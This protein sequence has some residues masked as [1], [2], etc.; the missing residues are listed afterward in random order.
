MYKFVKTLW[1]YKDIPLAIGISKK[2]FL[3]KAGLIVWRFNINFDSYERAMAKERIF[4]IR[5]SNEQLKLYKQLYD[6][7]EKTIKEDESKPNKLLSMASEEE[8]NKIKNIFDKYGEIE[9]TDE[10]KNQMAKL[11]KEIE[12]LEERKTSHQGIKLTRVLY[13]YE[14]SEEVLKKIRDDYNNHK[15]KKD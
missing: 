4:D 8:K 7:D 14:P 3:I 6:F 13:G 5:K 10:I 2:F 9:S 15:Q 1:K 12:L 11:K